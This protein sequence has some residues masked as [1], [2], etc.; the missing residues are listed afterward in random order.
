MM[1]FGWCLITYSH[2]PNKRGGTNKRGGG[3]I[4]NVESKDPPI[5]V[6]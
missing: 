2:L 4:M 3:K 6:Q 5:T 1:K